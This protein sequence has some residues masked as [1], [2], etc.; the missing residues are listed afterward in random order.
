MT[1]FQTLIVFLEALL[2]RESAKVC[3][4]LKTEKEGVCGKKSEYKTRNWHTSDLHLR[5]KASKRTFFYQNK[6]NF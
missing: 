6:T 4:N 5:K 3:H 2:G 1:I